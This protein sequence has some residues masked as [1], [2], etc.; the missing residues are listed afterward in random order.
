MFIRAATSSLL[1]NLLIILTIDKNKKLNLWSSFVQPTVIEND[2]EK[3]QIIS[4]LSW[5]QQMFCFNLNDF[6][7]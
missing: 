2:K 7:N 3:Q 4:T 5:N 6:N 1:M